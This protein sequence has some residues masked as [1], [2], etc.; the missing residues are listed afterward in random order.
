MLKMDVDALIRKNGTKGFVAPARTS[1]G[2]SR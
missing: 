2:N 1:Q